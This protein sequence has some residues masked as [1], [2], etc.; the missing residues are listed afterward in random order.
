MNTHILPAQT[1]AT[2]L[3]IPGLP[4]AKSVL[5]R[6]VPFGRPCF[7]AEE[8]VGDEQNVPRKGFPLFFLPKI[9]KREIASRGN[10]H[11][12]ANPVMTP[13]LDRCL[14]VRLR[15]MYLNG[16]NISVLSS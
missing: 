9:H 3:N 2:S 5:P 16:I 10:K 1:A 8:I 11:V 14:V 7:K 13:S 12:D 4:G 6:E 15:R